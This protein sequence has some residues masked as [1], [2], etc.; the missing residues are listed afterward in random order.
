MTG[1]VQNFVRDMVAK[2]PMRG[3]VLEVGSF[4]V[5]G[6]PRRWFTSPEDCP[7]PSRFLSYIGVDQQLGANVDIVMN[8]H[9]LEFSNETFSVVLSCEMIEHDTEFW[10][11]VEEMTRVLERGGYLILTTRSW[12]GCGPHGNYGDYWRFLPD[13]LRSLL[14]RNGLEC[15]EVVDSEAD[16]GMFACGRKP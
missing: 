14:E 9:R 4:D 12:R 1:E 7:D 2:Y 10:V 5:C 3:Y 16:D 13:G 6:N 11:S 15:L 8:A